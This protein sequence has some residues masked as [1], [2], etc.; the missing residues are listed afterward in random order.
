MT[1]KRSKTGVTFAVLGLAIILAVTSVWAAQEPSAKSSGEHCVASL[2]PSK[3]GAKESQLAGFKCYPSFADAISA[4]TDGAVKVSRQSDLRAQIESADQQIRSLPATASAF[5]L[6]I[7]Y[8]HANFVPSSLTWT[9]SAPYSSVLSFF[10]TRMP[11]GWDNR[12]SST[13]GFA[14]CNLNILFEEENFGGASVTCTP[15]CSY[16]GDAM[17]D[18]TSS[19]QWR[20]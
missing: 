17:N 12:V 3:P 20:F 10:K 18:R 1:S 2:Q 8:E 14:D 16:V 11:Q 6:A 19:R 5:V 15:T 7:D 9:G 13:R 4:A